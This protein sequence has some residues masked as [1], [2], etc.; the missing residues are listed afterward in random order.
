[1]RTG[2]LPEP[3]KTSATDMRG[4]A[5]KPRRQTP[6]VT[7]CQGGCADF[8]PGWQK[9]KSAAAMDRIG[10][11]RHFLT[12]MR[13]ILIAC[14]L[15]FVAGMPLAAQPRGGGA[16]LALVPPAWKLAPPDPN[17]HGAPYL[18]PQGDDWL[19]LF[20]SPARGGPVAHL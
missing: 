3:G 16:L 8:K 10:C 19:V 14:L 20:E 17:C 7:A 4:A 11:A 6:R 1:M 12:V 15:L 2:W 9:Q 18:S 5:P 13:R